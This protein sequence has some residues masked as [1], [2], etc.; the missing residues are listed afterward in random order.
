MAIGQQLQ[1]NN[2]K[3][4]ALPIFW[5]ACPT[6]LLA[7]SWLNY[8]F[9][10]HQ[11]SLTEPFM[12]FKSLALALAAATALSGAARAADLA[13]A[14]AAA[15]APAPVLG[16]DYAFG[17]ALMSDYVFRGVSQSDRKPSATAYGELRYNA[18][19]DVQFYAKTQVWKVNQPQA[20]AA[21]VDLLGGVR[22]T[23]GDFS[24]DI[25]GIYYLYP[26][27]KNQYWTN[28]ATTFL[29]PDFITLPGGARCPI[30][31]FCATTPKD[32]SYF[33][34]YV[35]PS[36]N[37]T[38]ALNVGANFYYS[39][40]WLNFGFDS[41]YSSAKAKYTFGE[42]GFSVSGELGYMKLGSL[43]AGTE[44]NAGPF[45]FKIPSYTTWNI[46]ASYAWNQ[47]T[48]DLRYSGAT[49]SKNAC[50][51]VSADPSGNRP[52]QA[53]SAQS[54]WCGNRFMATLSVDFVG[55]KDV[56]FPKW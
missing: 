31:P 15:P 38:S 55:S 39:N 4:A 19:P 30:G 56:T 49:L 12:K 9:R 50:Y 40:N 25:G 36:Y 35:M 8:D 34:A 21:E 16:F 14:P 45:P 5:A 41:L 23:F 17:M 43:K 47:V 33:E 29:N 20:P 32:S 24:A 7:M 27:N 11:I 18:T 3:R 48:L 22:L 10:K 28:G 46:G 51:L 1:S 42:T 44:L 52:F 53:P 13:A 2:V 6:L 26:D 37:I 54:N